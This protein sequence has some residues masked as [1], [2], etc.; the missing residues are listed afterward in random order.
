ELARRPDA[1]C[2]VYRRRRR[3]TALDPRYALA[4]LRPGRAS[5]IRSY[6]GGRLSGPY[7]YQTHEQ[8]PAISEGNGGAIASRDRDGD[9]REIA[10]AR[11]ADAWPRHPLSQTILRLAAERLFRRQTDDRRHDAS[12]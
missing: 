11:R 12:G 9:R 10:G 3:F 6:K 8:G 4:R 2:A 7:R 1:R 5:K